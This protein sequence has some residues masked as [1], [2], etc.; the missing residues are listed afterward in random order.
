VRVSKETRDRVRRAAEELGYRVW[1]RAPVGSGSIRTVGV[2]MDDIA[3]NP[4]SSFAIDAARKRAWEHGCVL[5]VLPLHGD[6]QLERRAIELLLAQRLI[7]VIYQS[8]FTRELSLPKRLRTTPVILVNCY[9]K[10]P[11]VPFVIPDHAEGAQSGVAELVAAGHTRIGFING[12]IS[13]EAA[14]DRLNGYKRALAAGGISPDPAL[15]R[16]GSWRMSRA[17]QETRALL[18]LPEP[19]TAIFCASD[20]MA[21]GCYEALKAAGLRVPE[22]MSVVGFDDDP[23]AAVLTPPLS[24]V[25]VPHARM[26]ELAV[27]YLLAQGEGEAASEALPRRIRCTFVERSSIA[28]LETPAR[29]KRRGRATADVALGES[30][31]PSS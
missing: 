30:E 29:Q 18:A 23:M 20:K 22:D 4:L 28:R 5:V 11:N 16:D 15:I 12:S 25:L 10:D 1:R 13:M 8:Y 31:G 19:P 26:G 3:Q 27:D 9:T 24:T 6:K 21:V 7:G 2:L 17:E 14:R